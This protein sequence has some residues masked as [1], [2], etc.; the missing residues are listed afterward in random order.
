M[1]SIKVNFP[2]KYLTFLNKCTFLV[3]SIFRPGK[4]CDCE[5]SPKCQ[6]TD[7]VLKLSHDAGTSATC[8]P[9]NNILFLK[10]HK[11]GSSTLTNIL[12]RF[13]DSRDL[14][15]AL[16]IKGYDFHWPIPFLPKSAMPTRRAP[17]IL[18][19]HARYNKAPMHWL[20]PKETTRY[21]TMLREPAEQFES[22]FNYCGLGRHFKRL[23]NDT[24]PMESFLQNAELYLKKSKDRYFKLLKNPALFDLGLQTVYHGNLTAVENYIHFLQ[25]EFDLVMLMEYFDESLVLLKRRFCWKMEDILYFKLNERTDKEK[26]NITSHTKNLIRKLNSADVLL[27]NVFNQTLWKMIEQEGAEFFED[28]ALF[29]KEKQSMEKACLQEGSFLTRPFG[30]KVVQGYKV[31]ANISKELSETC[32]K[33]IMNEIPYMDYLREKLT[34][35]QEA[36]GIAV[37]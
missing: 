27:Y 20:F 36:V 19:N 37:N 29:R 13:G 11:T 1:G 35:Q 17:N 24:S 26:K 9:V 34:K 23:P 18:S 28:L 7:S 6:N 12:N 33:M 14:L 31:K 4:L 16:P 15:F 5:G 30:R 10:T 2:T 22:V 32:S 8:R 25:Q 3:S 21:I